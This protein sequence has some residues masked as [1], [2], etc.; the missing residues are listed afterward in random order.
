M[1]F[2]K[3]VIMKIFKVVTETIYF[4]KFSQ[5]IQVMINR[6]IFTL[7]FSVYIFL[8]LL[9]SILMQFNNIKVN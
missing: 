6:Q 3:M 7:L 9:I 1:M 2:K 8:Q 4:K 5:N